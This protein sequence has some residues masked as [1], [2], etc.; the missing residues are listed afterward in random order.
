MEEFIKV[1][2]QKQNFIKNP[3]DFIYEN[4]EEP[5][6]ETIKKALSLILKHNKKILVEQTK[7][8]IIK[9]ELIEK[10]QLPQV[11]DENIS[12]SEPMIKPKNRTKKDVSDKAETLFYTLDEKEFTSFMSNISLEEKNYIKLEMLKRIIDFKLK[13]K[14]QIVFN[15]GCDISKI[16]EDLNRAR[17]VLTLLN[18]EKIEEENIEEKENSKVL[19]LPNKKNNTYLYDDICDNIE[20]AKEIKNTIDKV[21]D[22]YFLKTKDIKPILGKT[23]KLYE[24]KHPNGIRILYIVLPNDYVVITGLF[25]KDKDKSTRIEAFYDESINRYLY[26]KDYINSNIENPEFHI[27]QAELIGNIFDLFEKTIKKEKGE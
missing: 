14:E 2:E 6:N 24:Y 18:E 1:L 5:T 8:N 23:E 27:E 11:D 3:L 26:F 22:G 16:Q 15:P 4:L 7:E 25:Y 9:R 12:E 21:I 17:Q 20:S 19:I 13:I 10:A